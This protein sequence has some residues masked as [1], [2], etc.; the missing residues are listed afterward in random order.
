MTVYLFDLL[1]GYEPNGVDRSQANRARIFKKTNLDVRYIFSV[2]PPREDFLYFQHIGIP[3]DKMM[4]APFYLAG[5]KGVKSTIT[6]EEM[7]SRLHLENSPIVERDQHQIVCQISEDHR[8]FLKCEDGIVYQVDH[9]YQDTLY[10]RDHYTSYLICREWFDKGTYQWSKRCFYNSES[11]VVYEGFQSLGKTRYRFGSEWLEG[12]YDLMQ[13]FI[14][15]LS[16]SSADVVLM[17]R[18]SRFSFSQAIL[19]YGNRAKIGV[20]LHSLHQYKTGAMNNEYHYLFQ[21]ATSFDFM[22]VSTE[23]QKTDLE[24]Y[25]REMGLPSCLICVIPAASIESIESNVETM[26]P[27]SAMLAARLNY[28]KQVDI[29]IKVGAKVK[30]KI[31]EF[32][33]EYI[34]LRGYQNLK[35]E[36]KKHQLYLSTS[37][38]ETLG[39][40]LLEG[41]ASG[42]GLVGLDVPYGAPTFIQNGKN[43]YLVPYSEGQDKEESVE[44]MTK[45]VLEFFDLNQNEVSQHSYQIATSY[46]DEVIAEKWLSLLQ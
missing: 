5:A 14:K 7:I 9:F 44:R 37:S 34:R 32:T 17:D 2:I 38:W 22:I 3:L 20:F 21:N 41:V 4:I 27:Y 46:L 12:E 40:T 11:E 42:M 13:Y 29:A 28:R 25:L 19:E 10:Q 23:A 35:E 1:V 45:A 15:S 6:S 16:L 8:L 36:Y 30:E 31:P 26:V 43:G 18:V 39:L 24:N 33:E